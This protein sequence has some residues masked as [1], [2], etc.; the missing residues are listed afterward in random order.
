M[1]FNL[2]MSQWYNYIL[3]VLMIA[4]GVLLLIKCSDIFVDSASYFAKKLKIP[5]F[6]IGL[7]VVAF[8][9]SMPELAVSASDSIA[10]LVNGG[11][12]NISIGNVVG[13]NICNILLVLGCSLLITPIIVQKDALRYEFPIMIGTSVLATVFILSFSLNGAFAIL[14]WEGIILVIGIIAYVTYLV[15]SAK[16][17]NSLSPT[18]EVDTANPEK[19]MSIWKAVLFLLL[20]LAGIVIG[21][22]LVVNG[23]KSVAV[24]IG[25]LAG[26][27]HD[28]VESLV[29]LT[30]VAVGTSLPELVTSIVAAK[31]GENE[32][33]L[34]NVIGSNIF[35][36]LFILGV[37][38]V[39]TPL[40]IGTQIIVDLVV[41]IVSAILAFALS[42]KKKLTKRDG[43]IFVLCY[44]AYVAYLI[45]RTVL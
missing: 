20:G 44:T 25:D 37:S 28:L 40:T 1:I 36:I 2:D 19:T 38:A 29:G 32:I 12:A 8:G 11:N 24:G 16:K 15:L 18:P 10:C 27:N 3:C 35:N 41:M 13:S 31:K 7:T 22:E 21:G 9:T 17:K 6:V 4:G 26:L 42:L 33:A 45:L 23:A 5:S 34:G 39:I 30:I 43:L 14:R